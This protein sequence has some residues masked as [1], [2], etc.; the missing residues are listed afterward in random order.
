MPLSF[1]KAMIAPFIIVPDAP[2]CHMLLSASGVF[3]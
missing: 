3:G 1:S 2:A